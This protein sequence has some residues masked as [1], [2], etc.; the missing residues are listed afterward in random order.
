M[1]ILRS[2][3]VVL[4][5]TLGLPGQADVDCTCSGKIK[6]V[7][8]GFDFVCDG[9]CP[10]SSFCFYY[11]IDLGNGHYAISC[12]CYEVPGSDP[13][14]CSGRACE[15]GLE[16]IYVNGGSIGLGAWCGTIDCDNICVPAP[17]PYLTYV[18]PCR[19]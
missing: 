16:I 9:D 11:E 12:G 3:L 14:V 15:P 5:C 6:T 18:D 13:V 17:G 19:C 1:E 10:G 4:L 8:E 2:I 7:D